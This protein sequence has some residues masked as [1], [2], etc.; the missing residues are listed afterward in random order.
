VDDF[1]RNNSIGAM[2]YFIFFKWTDDDAAESSTTTC[3]EVRKKQR[4]SIVDLVKS[5]T[6]LFCLS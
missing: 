4:M 3:R 5:A 1:H 2:K 6:T